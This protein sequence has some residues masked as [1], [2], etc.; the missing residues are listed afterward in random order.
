MRVMI[1]EDSAVVRQL[2]RAIIESDGHQVV[3]AQDGQEAL[4]LL[5][6]I[7][8]DIITMDVHMP[9]LDGFQ[10]TELILESYGVPIIVVTASANVHATE[11]AMQA[12]AA[13]ALAVIEKPTG[14]GDPIFPVVTEELLNTINRLGGVKV[15][16]RQRKS[17][18][19]VAEVD[20]GGW[21]G[22]VEMVAIGASAGGPMALKAFLQGLHPEC[23]WPFLLVQ[24]IATGFLPSF[25]DWLDSVS[26]LPVHVARAREA[27][28][29]GQI[30]LAPDDHH[31][32]LDN[33]GRFMLDAGERC[34]G[35]RPSATYLFRSLAKLP[36]ASHTVAIIFSGMG[37]DGSE[38]MVELKSQGALTLV[39]DP[40]TSIVDGMPQAAIQRGV[41]SCI[42][43]AEAM[44]RAINQLYA[45]QTKTRTSS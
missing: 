32:G 33:R 43:T 12:L 3:E 10:T 20:L 41:V 42:L 37:K 29:P 6:Q 36:L 30:Y 14:P 5:H 24:H 9:G 28:E 35:V 2:L 11:T 21:R 45:R 16:T 17:R 22:P 7:Q 15:V 38:G 27:P 26:P 31:L 34:E 8:P 25:R 40:T 44:T 19:T 1:V 23:P 18:L 13:G 4:A 39:Q